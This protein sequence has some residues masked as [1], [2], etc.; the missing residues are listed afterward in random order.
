MFLGIIFI[1]II[2]YFLQYIL[3][4]FIFRII[5]KNNY[6]YEEFFKIKY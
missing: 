1:I 2:D 3:F 5:L 6:N 4:I